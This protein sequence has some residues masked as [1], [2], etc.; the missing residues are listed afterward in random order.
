MIEIFRNYIRIVGKINNFIGGVV[1]VLPLVVTIFSAYEVAARYLFAS[2]TI[3]VWD[4]N[5]QLFALF[6]LLSGGYTLLYG[7]HISVDYFTGKLSAKNKAIADLLTSAFFFFTVFL[8][9][10]FGWKIA[11]ESWMAKETMATLW[12]PPLYTLKMMIP[13]GAALMLLQGI[14]KYMADIILLVKGE[15]VKLYE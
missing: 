11:W 4:L 14:A 6:V 5:I 10:F 15:E 3:W 1:S 7:G 8:L 12:G 13:V 9:I 2:P